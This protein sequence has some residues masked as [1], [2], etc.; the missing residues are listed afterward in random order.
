M[1]EATTIND[2]ARTIPRIH[3]ALEDQ[4]INHQASVVE[5]EGKISKKYVSILIDPGSSHTILHLKLLTYVF[6]KN[7]SIRNH[8]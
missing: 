7:A 1:Q 2:I 6:L 5:V 4:Q 8:G 3:V